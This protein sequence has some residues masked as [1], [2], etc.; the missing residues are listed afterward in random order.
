MGKDI[1]ESVESKSV[2]RDKY[3]IA[4]ELIYKYQRERL[5]ET[6]SDFEGIDDLREFFFEMIYP[7]PEKRRKLHSRNNAYRK[8]AKSRILGILI[9]ELAIRALLEIIELEDMTELINKELVRALCEKGE[10]PE[11]ME[12]SYYFELCRE[13]SDPL[14][15]KRQIECAADG[16]LLVEM[17]V[18]YTRFNLNQ[19]VLLVPKP[20]VRNSDLLDMSISAFLC[21]SNHKQDLE[22][23]RLSMVERE[24]KYVEEMFAT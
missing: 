7:P 21:F 16:F 4:E 17:F 24:K 13:V 1:S 10:L 5:E 22:R 15:R 2:S 23:L 12:R 18:K 3:G 8:A 11:R 19:I 14:Q 20:L 9:P 6:Y